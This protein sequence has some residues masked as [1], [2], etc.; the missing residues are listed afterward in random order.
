MSRIRDVVTGALGHHRRAQCAGAIVLALAGCATQETVAA[1]GA[2]GQVWQ[3]EQ[4]GGVP[5][6]AT[7]ILTFPE[8]GRISGQAP[9][10][11]YAATT[12]APYP[13]FD[14]SP[15]TATRKT[16]ADQPAETVFFRALGRMTQSEVSGAV[17]I[18]RDDAGSEMVFKA[19]D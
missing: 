3:L 16:C 15:I 5:F 18:L 10:N 19:A 17:L 14:I 2:A 6:S 7:A 12:A 11:S 8:P 1:Y 9:C 13:W 4:I